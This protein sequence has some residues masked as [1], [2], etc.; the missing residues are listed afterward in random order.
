MLVISY[1]SNHYNINHHQHKL[2][3]RWLVFVDIGVVYPVQC[4][5][6]VIS[7]D[8]NNYNINLHQHRLV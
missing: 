4:D 1:D 7:Y 3:E 6:L 2:V 8:S 5:V